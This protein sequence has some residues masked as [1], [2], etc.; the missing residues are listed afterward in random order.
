MTCW[1]FQTLSEYISWFYV[2]WSTSQKNLDMYIWN[3]IKSK[4]TQGLI[5]PV[6]SWLEK[7]VCSLRFNLFSRLIVFK[8]F[9]HPNI[10]LIKKIFAKGTAEQKIF[11][12][13]SKAL[14]NFILF[15]MMNFICIKPSLLQLFF[16]LWLIMKTGAKD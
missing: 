1:S 9:I 15:K 5:D 6:C 11:R 2:V 13:R 8:V 4:S 7:Q 14:K 12:G 16:I 10:R 3:G